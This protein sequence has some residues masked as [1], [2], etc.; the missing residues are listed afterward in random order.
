[1]TMHVHL[2]PASVLKPEYCVACFVHTPLSFATE[3]VVF[4]GDKE[5]GRGVVVRV[6]LFSTAH[7]TSITNGTCMDLMCDF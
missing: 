3:N 7:L 6:Q 4:F 1:M 5:A 2:I